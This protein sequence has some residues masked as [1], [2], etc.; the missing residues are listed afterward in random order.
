VAAG[1]EGQRATSPARRFYVPSGIP[2]KN[3]RL[4]EKL[5]ESISKICSERIFIKKSCI[6]PCFYTKTF[7]PALTPCSG[8]ANLKRR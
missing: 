5:P 3:R 7:F 6:S 2:G 1:Y 4:K 8:G